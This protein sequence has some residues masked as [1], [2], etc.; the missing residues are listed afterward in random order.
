MFFSAKPYYKNKSFTDKSV[1]L[2]FTGEP[3]GTIVEPLW[4]YKG[5]L[6]LFLNLSGFSKEYKQSA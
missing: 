4:F 6:I 5:R 3:A 1:K 2:E